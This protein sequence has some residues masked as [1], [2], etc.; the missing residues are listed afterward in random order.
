MSSTRITDILAY[1]WLVFNRAHCHMLI[2]KMYTKMLSSIGIELG[3]FVGF[4]GGFWG[5]FKHNLDSNN[6]IEERALVFG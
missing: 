3:F 5:F 2:I 6:R 1:Q 4:C